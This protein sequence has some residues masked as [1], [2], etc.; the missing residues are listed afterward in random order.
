MSHQPR[1]LAA[2]IVLLFAVG[3]FEI[4]ETIEL[5]KDLSGTAS[6]KIGVDM[7]P[8]I[9]IMAKVQKEMSGDTAA[10][11]ADDIAKARAE[12]KKNAKKSSS[13]TADPRAEAEKGLPPGVKLLDATI[14]EREF[15]MTTTMKF[16]FENL[17]SLV[18]VKLGSGGGEGGD[19][20]KKTVIESPFEGLEVIET[21]KT[22]SLRAKPQNPAEE[23]KADAKEQAPQIDPETEKL[24][25]DAFKSLRVA[26]KI[27]A[28]F[29]VVSHN[30][31]RVEGKTLIWEYD[32][33][34]FQKLAAAGAKADE[35]GVHVTYRK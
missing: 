26:W 19:P 3:C 13:T 8:M 29:E 10:L 6:F 9:A 11:T 1:V 21:D 23:V 22:I 28:P 35:L 30:A 2:A 12:F 16:A 14:A 33:E 32:L 18:G 24:M 7:E 4:E 25:N 34:R 15:G 31:T 5:K 17:S 20:T 27:T